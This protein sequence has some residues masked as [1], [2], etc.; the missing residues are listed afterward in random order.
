MIASVTASTNNTNAFELD[1][2]LTVHGACYER[3]VI[4][5]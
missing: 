3:S 4:D 2:R 1:I 5:Q